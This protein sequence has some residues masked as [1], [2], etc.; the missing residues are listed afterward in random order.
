MTTLKRLLILGGSAFALAA[1]TGTFDLDAV[2]N[3]DSQG[4]AF[5]KA[6]HVE[7]VDLADDERLESDWA[8]AVFFNDRARNAANAKSFGPQNMGDRSI[9]AK[10][11]PAMSSARA[12]LIAALE[13]GGAKRKPKAAARAQ[14]MFDC[15][16]QEQEENFQPHDIAR[17]RANFEAAMKQ[18]QVKKVVKFVPEPFKPTPPL[19]GPFVVYFDF[20]KSNLDKTANEVV[21]RAIGAA[22]RSGASALILGGHTD[23][24]GKEGYNQ[25]LSQ[26]RVNAVSGALSKSGFAAGGIGVRGFGETRPSRS[27]ADGI[28]EQLNRRVE[29][30]LSR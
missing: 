29:I 3:M 9:P 25:K 12:R 18:L 14:A 10:A 6:L 2:K 1:C 21:K 24:A 19:P 15:W 22:K 26:R 13:A 23:R 5:Q 28:P 11:A 20:D 17:C 8:D 27:T 30:E 16:M 7:Y 4:S